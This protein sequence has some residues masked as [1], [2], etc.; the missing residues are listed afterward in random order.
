[1]RKQVEKPTQ[2]QWKSHDANMAEQ[3]VGGLGQGADIHLL[4]VRKSLS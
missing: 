4:C 3:T 2:G 1:M